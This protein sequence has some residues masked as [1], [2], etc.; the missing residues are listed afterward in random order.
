V[1]REVEARREFWLSNIRKV[2]EA[3]INSE[4]V[5]VPPNSDSKRV[6]QVPVKIVTDDA[7][8]AKYRKLDPDVTHP[9]RL[10]EVVDIVNDRIDDRDVNRYDL[11]S[12]N[13]VHDI[14]KKEV[15]CHD[16]K[17]SS[18]QYSTAFVDWIVEKYEE[19]DDFF[20]KAREGYYEIRYGR[21]RGER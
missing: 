13:K 1:S 16:P 20:D 3:P 15:F 17:F 14:K 6:T 21:K 19:D 10:T 4:V 9:Y 12:I 2:V 5:L 8:A 11:I 7:S 18:P